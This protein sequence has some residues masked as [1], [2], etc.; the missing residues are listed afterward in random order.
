MA[1]II[2]ETFMRQLK[3]LPQKE[4]GIVSRT[5]LDLEMDP[6]AR[7]LSLHRVDGNG[8]WWSAYANGDL[9]IILKREGDGGMILCW[10]D[11]HDKA[12][13]WAS[14]HV[15]TEHPV[16]HVMQIVEIP[17]VTAVSP[18]PAPITEQGAHAAATPKKTLCDLVGVGRDDLLAFG[19]PEAWI[20]RVMS[21][22]DEDEL[23]EMSDHYLSRAQ[24]FKR[25]QEL[26]RPEPL[27]QNVLN[28]LKKEC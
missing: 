15:L 5:V 1:F 4:Q 8:G 3:R 27:F 13:L 26:N 20:E 11:H 12:Y 14:R 22:T 25:V 7:T 10:T 24:L 9:R 2:A 19:V 18:V 23:L 17:E 16:T 6:T 21:A 28:R